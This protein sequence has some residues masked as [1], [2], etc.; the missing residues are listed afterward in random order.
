MSS[1]ALL[2]EATKLLKYAIGH[3]YIFLKLL[4]KCQSWLSWRSAK[5]N[6]SPRT[7]RSVAS[8]RASFHNG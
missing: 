8:E 1:M 5:R 2:N 6:L 3:I 7:D 4:V